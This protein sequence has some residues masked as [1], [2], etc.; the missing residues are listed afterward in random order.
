M[1]VGKRRRHAAGKGAVIRYQMRQAGTAGR[2]GSITGTLAGPLSDKAA[3]EAVQLFG[4]VY[5]GGRLIDEA[6]NRPDGLSDGEQ[7]QIV[8]VLAEDQQWQD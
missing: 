8:K 7:A 5:H 4:S 6:F 1:S 2:H 3:T